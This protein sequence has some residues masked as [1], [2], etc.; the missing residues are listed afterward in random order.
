MKIISGTSNLEL[1]KNIA[2]HLQKPLVSVEITKFHNQ[3]KRVW[4]RDQVKGENVVLVQSFSHPTDE[5]IMEFLLLADALQRLGARHINAVIP[6]LG[7]S[8]QDK[9]FRDGEPIAAKVIADL[10]SNAGVKRAFLL[11]LHNTSTPGFFNIPTQHISALEMFAQYIQG[12][13]PHDQVVVASPDF[14]GLKRAR[15][16]ANL[17][18]VPLAKIDKHRDLHGGGVTAVDVLGDVKDKIVVVFDDVINTG[19]TVASCAELLKARGAQGVHF[20]ATHGIFANNGIALIE[21]SMADSVV[22]SN[23]IPLEQ[24]STKIEVVD[25]S[26]LFADALK[27]WVE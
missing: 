8:L 7:Y 1:A 24:K 9:V 4:I 23:S 12:H 20:F 15:V 2:D 11:D 27:T 22:I 6:W 14:G 26:G 25:V 18:D 16:L 10:V 5:H 13:F 19:S 17:L 3:E 21:N